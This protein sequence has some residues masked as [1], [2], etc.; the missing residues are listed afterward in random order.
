MS[1]MV[2]YVGLLQSEPNLGVKLVI[3]GKEF[4]S[5]VDAP[6]GHPLGDKL[7][8]G[9]HYRLKETREMAVDDFANPALL[10]AGYGEELWSKADGKAGKSCA[11]C[12]NDATASMKGVR[13]R[14]PKWDE[15][16]KKPIAL[17]Q[18]INRCRTD[19]MEAKA[20]KW[21]SNQM[22]GMTS[23]V[24]LQSR[25]M[26][27]SIKAEG[28]MKEWIEKGKKLY[29]KPVGQLE[30]ACAG[31]HEVNNGRMIRADHLSQGHINGFPTYRLKWRK[32]G[33]MHRRFAGCMKNIR[34]QPFKR[35][36]DEFL[37]LEAYLVS[38]GAGLA[39]ESPSLRN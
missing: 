8:S 38:R 30:M 33:S 21:E 10:A 34:A 9:W 5:I 12:H 32:M 39:V 31:C 19:R 7:I 20:W 11:S 26:P 2:A 35:G 36:S 25:G 18:L 1:G 23:Y 3:D 27:M 14:L 28:P 37:A 4:K 15:K 13:A 16:T 6:K 29:Y 17:E 22:L 24:A